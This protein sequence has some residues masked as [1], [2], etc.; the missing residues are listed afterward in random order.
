MM[1]EMKIYQIKITLDHINPPIWRRIQVPGN[2]SLL[3]FHFILQIA[4]GWTNSHLHEFQIGEERFG[5]SFEDDWGGPEYELKE[6]EQYQLEQ[7]IPA[8]GDSFSYLYDFGDSWEHTLEVEEILSP[9]AAQ[10]YPR[11][12][13]G[14][15]ACPPEDVG[16]PWGYEDFL[17][18]IKNP[19]H[20]EHEDYLRWIGGAFE[21]E[22]F[23][24]E[25][26]DL[27]LANYRLSEMV[28]V[29]RRHYLGGKGPELTMYQAISKWQEQLTNEQRTQFAEL[30]LR[31]DAVT[32]LT[33]LD[34]H[35]VRGT[36][37][38]GNLTLKAV[39]EVTAMFVDPPV[40]DT[41][42]GDRVYKLRT[43]F[44]IWPLY[45][46]HSLVEVG[47]LLEGGP[48]K[49]FRLTPTG[50]EFLDLDFPIQ[51]W[52]LLE[53]WWYHVNW[54]IAYPYQGMGEQLPF[55]F[56]YYTVHRLL[57]LPVEQ[58]VLFRDFA[59]RLI[60]R[61]LLRWESENMA[62]A[63]DSLRSSIRRM[64]ID[65][66]ERFQ[67]VETQMKKVPLGNSSYQEL[68]AFTIT[69]LGRGLLEVLAGT[70]P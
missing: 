51:V 24:P 29:Y 32:L 38:T 16:G 65:V 19:D 66:L 53:T 64:V 12:L 8:R 17:E 57:S 37:S 63:R 14:A 67:A 26:R 39:R 10:S 28:R 15:R 23:D 36:Q 11:C 18:A 31:R 4:M 46:L 34:N 55:D 43:E 41:K 58:S 1:S 35:S 5:T 50:R 7:V 13:S 30:P 52:F 33:Y 45:F 25:Q 68:H 27:E 69:R 48:G 62:R 40:L 2:V 59:D 22:A 6:E 60:E 70:V 49:K 3:Q 44:D 47:G 9:S 56:P 54:L 20:P 42:I 61:T 21:P